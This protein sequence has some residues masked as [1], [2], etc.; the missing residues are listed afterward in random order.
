MQ[1]ISVF[2]KITKITDF[3]RKNADDSRTEEVYHNIYLFFGSF[4]GKVLL[5]QV[6]SF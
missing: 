6:Q 5:C 3:R 4:L 1:S 2:L